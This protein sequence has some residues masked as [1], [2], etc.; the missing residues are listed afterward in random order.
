MLIDWFTVGAQALNFLILVWLLK[1]FLYKPVLAA[2][3]VREKRIA[4]EL[5]DAEKKKADAAKEQA[6]FAR[7]NEEFEGQRSALL[8]EATNAA[9]TEREKLLATAR[10]EAE[11]LR[12]KLEKAVEGEIDGLNQKM[13]T[14]AREEVFSI[15]RKT[16][17]DL[18]GVSLEERMVEAFIQRLHGMKDEERGAL[19]TSPDSAR[20]PALVRS[21]FELAPPLRKKLEE[22]IAPFLFEG[23]SIEFGTRSDLI[24]GIE[25]AANGR[26]IAWNMATYLT[27]LSE[28]VDALLKPKAVLAPAALEVVHAT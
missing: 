4:A 3:D 5:K 16:L 17:T 2:I 26:K 6:D 28:A 8:L 21:A 11:A 18:A 25:L 10:Q 27:S 14:L 12:A 13:G 24:S 9:K 22:A 20:K 19:K 1:R 15:A 7:K 23:T